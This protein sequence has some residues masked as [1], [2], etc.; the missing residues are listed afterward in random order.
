MECNENNKRII[1]KVNFYKNNYLKSHV[2]II[3]KP[4]FRNGTFVSV[5]QDH[6]FFWFIE[7]KS[8]IPI[9]LFLNEIYDI[10]DYKE[11]KEDFV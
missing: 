5:L 10:E 11:K 8:H 6:Q 4:K 3:P 2:L 7:L 9:R 1:E